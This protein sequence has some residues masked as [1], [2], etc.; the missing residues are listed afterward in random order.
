MTQMNLF[1]KRKQTHRHRTDL[2]VPRGKGPGEG[3][4]GKLRS[5]EASFYIYETKTA[6]SL[7][8]SAGNYIQYPGMTHNAKAYKKDCMCVCVNYTMYIFIYKINTTL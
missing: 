6:R 1:M 3:W 5:A 2:W 8:Y 7:S 4:S